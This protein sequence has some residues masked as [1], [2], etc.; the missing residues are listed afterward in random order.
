[1]EGKGYPKIIKRYGDRQRNMVRNAIERN[2]R[3]GIKKL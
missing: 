3:N 1:M 2:I